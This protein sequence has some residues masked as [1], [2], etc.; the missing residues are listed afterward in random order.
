MAK[1][2]TV[3]MNSNGSA[4]CSTKTASLTDAAG[5]VTCKLCLR[6]LNPVAKEVKAPTVHMAG[7]AGALCGNPKAKNVSTDITEITCKSCLKKLAKDAAVDELKDENDAQA[8]ADA[9]AIEA[10]EQAA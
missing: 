10:Y 7:G 5:E 6:K 2:A 8:D 4:L 3:H 1:I 9:E